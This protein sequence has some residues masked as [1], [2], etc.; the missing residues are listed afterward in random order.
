MTA[1]MQD[2]V[3]LCQIKRVIQQRKPEWQYIA[4]MMQKRMNRMNI[5]I[6]LLKPNVHKIIRKTKQKLL[7][8]T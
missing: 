3:T 8:Q 2:I 1:D 7:K 4:T 5:I 6:C